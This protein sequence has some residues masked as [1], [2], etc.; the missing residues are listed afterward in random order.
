LPVL[1]GC[2]IGAIGYAAW[3]LQLPNLSLRDQWPLI[4]LAGAGIGLL[5]GPS[6]TDAV[7]RAIDASY[8]EVTGI[9]QTIRNYGSSLGLAVLGAVLISQLT[10]RV[11]DSLVGLGV[12][13]DRAGAVATALSQ[14]GRGGGSP[15]LSAIP[16]QNRGK[17]FPAIQ[18]DY[19][20]ASR[21]VFL[22]MAAA[23]V[24]SFFV[25]LFHP[26]G[27]VVREATATQGAT[28]EG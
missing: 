3:G 5:L 13:A 23:L 14:Q 28:V 2:A 7:N 15:D 21:V 11:T 6:S 26:G 8:G 16:P 10:T 19:A 18:L 24:I 25:A 20:Q 17:V 27:K 4:V 22:G 1:L 9:T 12:P